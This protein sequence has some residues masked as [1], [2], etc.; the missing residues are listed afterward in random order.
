MSATFAALR[1]GRGSPASGEPGRA[2]G[3]RGTSA[4]WGLDILS[5]RLER[6]ALVEAGVFQ[7]RIAAG[8]G[9]GG[10]QHGLRELVLG[11]ADVGR[12][13]GHPVPAEAGEDLREPLP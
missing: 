9:A 5:P 3:G 12:E 4:P 2:G 11:Q 10:V 8:T 1:G 13:A 6:L 7:D